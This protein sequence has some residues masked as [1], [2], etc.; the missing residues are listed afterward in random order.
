MAA[1][2]ESPAIMV[3]VISSVQPAPTWPS[4]L[5]D[6]PWSPAVPV[7][8]SVSVPSLVYCTWTWSSVPPRFHLR[9]TSLL[10]LCESHPLRGCYVTPVSWNADDSHQRALVLFPWLYHELHLPWFIAWAHYVL[11]PVTCV[12]LSCSVCSVILC[13]ILLHICVTLHFRMLF[14]L[15]LSW[16]CSSPGGFD[17]MHVK[18]IMIMD[19][20]R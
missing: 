6:L 1:K 7:P 16:S 12:L 18:G 2:P 8:R 4:A 14:L 10:D 5:P 17:L 19:C 20:T 13:E 11:I 15:T 9:T 3:T